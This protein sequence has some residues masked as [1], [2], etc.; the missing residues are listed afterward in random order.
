MEI[1]AATSRI[2]YRDFIRCTPGIYSQEFI[3]HSGQGIQP[4]SDD[5]AGWAYFAGASQDD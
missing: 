2:K 4:K 3:G 1:P 5:F